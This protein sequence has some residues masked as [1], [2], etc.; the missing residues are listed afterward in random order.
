MRAK[1]SRRFG[2]LGDGNKSLAKVRIVHLLLE[3][4]LLRV[5]PHSPTKPMMGFSSSLLAPSTATAA[6][7]PHL[8]RI[9]SDL[10]S[11][12]RLLDGTSCLLR[13]VL[14]R[15]GPA[16]ARFVA[17]LSRASRAARFPGADTLSDMQVAE[18]TEVDFEHHVGYVV[19]LAERSGERIIGEARFM[20]DGSSGSADIALV[21]ADDWHRRHIAT[22]AVL[23]MAKAASRRGL[24]W[25]RADVACD[26]RPM[27]SL[28]QRC[29]FTRTPHP[30]E[31]ELVQLHLLLL[32]PFP[33]E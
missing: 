16:L 9:P 20:V 18:L 28:L 32:P 26:N 6:G 19:T 3:A 7:A 27:L 22:H 15:D 33:G 10:S 29:G 8:C 4:A 21:V 25:L 24:R 12:C 17:G 31:A 11:P 2:C 23:A 13:P 1:G 30:H 14:P 5:T